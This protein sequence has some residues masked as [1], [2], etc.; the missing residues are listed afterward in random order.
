MPPSDSIRDPIPD[1]DRYSRQILF[2]GIGLSGQQLLSQSRIA[3]IGVG[4]VR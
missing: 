2:H 4:S 1:N 3:I